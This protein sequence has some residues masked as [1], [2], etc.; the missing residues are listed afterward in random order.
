MRCAISKLF[1]FEAFQAPHPPPVDLVPRQS[2][3]ERRKG[4]FIQHRCGEKLDIRILEHQPDT[5]AKCK[6]EFIVPQ[7]FFGKRLAK[8]RDG[9]AGGK[10]ETVKQF[11]Q[12]AFSAAICAKNDKRFPNR[13][14]KVTCSSAVWVPSY[15]KNTS[16]TSKTIGTSNLIFLYLP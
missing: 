13:H 7:G 1:R 9:T 5:A 8:C 11:Q 14:F 12:T 16:Q 2:K 10:I 3:L 15:A 6:V 4:N